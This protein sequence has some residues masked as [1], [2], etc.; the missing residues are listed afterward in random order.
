[1]VSVLIT[2]VT[3]PTLPY[4][5][6]EIFLHVRFRTAKGNETWLDNTN[7]IKLTKCRSATEVDVKV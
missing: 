1:M 7:N 4:R 2:S 5:S 3:K 6:A